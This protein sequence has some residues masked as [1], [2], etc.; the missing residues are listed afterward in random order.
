LHL[1]QAR[2]P[3]P[4][5]PGNADRQY[6][7]GISVA[8]NRLFGVVV[9]LDGEI[10]DS[11]VQDGRAVGRRP[12]ADKDTETVMAG[13]VRLVE[14]LQALSPDRHRV[15]GMGV[16]VG[17]HVNG[18]S[19]RVIDSPQLKWE[20]SFPLAERLRGTTGFKTVA[21]ENDV[22]A[23]AVGA[24]YFGD[25]TE[26][27]FAVVN[28]ERGLG[29]GL[30]LNHELFR[31]ASGVAGEFGHFPLV[32]NGARCSCGRH[33]CLE[34][35]VGGDAILREM[36]NAGQPIEDID[37]GVDLVRSGSNTAQEIFKQ[38][39]EALGRSLAGLINLLNLK[40]VM[41]CATRAVLECDPYIDAVHR[42]FDAHAFS[43]AASDCKLKLEYRTDELEARGAA[44]LAFANEGEF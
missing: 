9:D 23:L 32:R 43:T 3:A 25:A 24:Q 20:R 4:S 16:S 10:V 15:V 30:V 36:E 17:G 13:I 12:L 44:S 35:V 6:S 29:V 41:L 1:G 37:A 33:G 39:G 7:I 21:V 28:L 11:P 40:L 38:Q 19:G 27:H 31:G 5:R 22:N 8:K 2:S 14:E 18:P 26:P 42:S 34:T